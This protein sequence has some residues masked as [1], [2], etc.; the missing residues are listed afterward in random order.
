MDGFFS[1]LSLWPKEHAAW[2]VFHGSSHSWH[3]SCTYERLNL[4]YYR[5]WISI[6]Y[7]VHKSKV[8]LA[9]LVEGDQKA[10]FSIANTLRWRGGYYSFT[11]IAPLYPW[12]VP[13]IA[14]CY[15]RRYQVPFLK[16]LVWRDLGLNPWS[17]R[18]LANILPSGPIGSEPEWGWHLVGAYRA[19]L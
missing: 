7:H 4:C 6:S 11:W 1:N 10:P 15:A 2:Y 3:K 16:S 12:Y 9:T 18:P 14:E 8:K 17:P 13:Y 5:L 19:D